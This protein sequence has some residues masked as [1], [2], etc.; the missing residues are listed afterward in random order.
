MQNPQDPFENYHMSI[1]V[2]D[3]VNEMTDPQKCMNYMAGRLYEQSKNDPS[4][5]DITMKQIKD[6]CTNQNLQNNLEFFI[7]LCEETNAAY[8]NAFNKS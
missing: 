8:K 7:D 2:M 5:K 6:Y 3:K 1:C 4:V